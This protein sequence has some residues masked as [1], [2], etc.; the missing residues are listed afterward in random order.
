[1]S[2]AFA[3]L[4][5]LQFRE[6]FRKLRLHGLITKDGAKVSKSSGN[7]ASPDVYLAQVWAHNLRGYLLFSGPWEDGGDFSDASL[8]EI[9]RFTSRAFRLISGGS[10]PAKGGVD[11][12]PLD[13]F[14]ARAWGRYTQS[15]VQHSHFAA[16]GGHEL[17]SPRAA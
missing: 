15:E 3:D 17:V 12:R 6:P 2:K 4:K 10:E 8:Q 7:V 5:Y 14:I 13:R 11:M 16:D 9:V 1:M